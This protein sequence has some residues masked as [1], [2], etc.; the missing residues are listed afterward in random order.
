[1]LAHQLYRVASRN[2]NW[3]VFGEFICFFRIVVGIGE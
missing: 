1:M 2:L 3:P